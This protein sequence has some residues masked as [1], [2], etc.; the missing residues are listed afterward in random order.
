MSHSAVTMKTQA[1]RRAQA[2]GRFNPA[3]WGIYAFLLTAALFFLAPLYIMLVTSFKTMEEI[4]LG[5]LFALPMNA[6][7]EPWRAAWSEVCTGVSCEG[8]SAG[9]W[10]SVAI[11]VPSTILPV[12][13]GALNGYALSFWRPR[14]AHV[15]FGILMLG[16]FIP[17]QV[18]IY[19]LVKVMAAVGLYSS[20]PGIVAVHLIFSMPVMT[21]LFRNYYSAIPPEL[22]KAARID[23]G[24][25]W[26]IFVQLMLPMSTPIIVVAAIMQVTG[27]WNDYILGLVFAGREHLPMTV[28]LNNVINTTT[29]ERLYNVNMAATI[30]TSMVPLLVYF[31]SG[32]WFV[33]GI[34][35]GAVKG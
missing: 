24:G 22:F 4:R 15:L 29:G 2:R 35:A 16:A 31:V 7:L 1:A 33:R 14:G 25:F 30:L 23:G 32:R 17:V 18:M 13:I 20:L 10:N 6:T 11:V 12:L 26:R 19:P 21:L 27:V 9:F 3:R 28:Q 5:Q 34:A 8:I